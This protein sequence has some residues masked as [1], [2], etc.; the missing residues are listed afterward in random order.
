MKYKVVELDENSWRIEEFNHNSHVYMY[1]LAG[2]EKAV[3]LDTGFG[4]I[5]LEKITKQITKLPIEVILTHGHVDHIGGTGFFEK[6]YL[7]TADRKTYG[8]HSQE[9]CRRLFLGD[10]RRLKAPKEELCFIEN[11]FYWDLGGRI[12]RMVYTPG[13]T[14]GSICIWDEQRS[15]L[16]TGD[17][18]CQ[19]HILL[20]L[21]Y[22]A[23]VRTY[24]SSIQ[25]LLQIPFQIT[26]PAHHN[27]PVEREI[28]QEFEEAAAML[29]RGQA[30]GKVIEHIGG[31]AR[32]FWWKRIGIVYPVEQEE[33]EV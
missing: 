13:H 14:Y 12:L 3:L 28:L 2:T 6:V 32:E 33:N 25:K 7:H 27:L 23:D 5:E 21:S 22:A 11:K 29:L 30:E 9:S 24:L 17:T 10:E 19:G 18:C 1:L 16:F 20:N 31:K 26:W 8:L 15:W 4:T